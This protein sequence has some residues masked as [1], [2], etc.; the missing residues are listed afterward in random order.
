V[1][2]QHLDLRAEIPQLALHRR[3]LALA[4]QKDQ[5]VPGRP[6]GQAPPDGAGGTRPGRFGRGLALVDHLDGEEARVGPQH[7]AVPQ[8]ARDRPRIERRRH[9]HELQIGAHFATDLGQQRQREIG[10]QAALVEL[11]ED[12][13][14][15]AV[16]EGITLQ[17]AGQQ[18]LGD[19]LDACLRPGAVLE[20]DTVADALAQAGPVLCGEAARD[21]PG[22]HPPRLQHHQAPVAEHAGLEQREGQ[23]GGLARA[24][25]GDDDRGARAGERVDERRDEGVDGQGGAAGS[26]RVQGQPKGP[27]VK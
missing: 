20:P 16:E 27:W 18:A 3:D 10:V 19:H 11:V 7:G 8:E 5:H 1:Q 24:R 13:A 14:R 6:L 25:R 4:G 9:D 15:D 17:A 26:D 2:R 22:G 12:D 21:G 23:A